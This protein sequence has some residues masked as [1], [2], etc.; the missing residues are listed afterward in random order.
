MRVKGIDKL[1]ALAALSVVI[2]HIYGSAIPGYWKYLFTGHP[3][4]IAFFVISGFC[5]HRPY[6]QNR[7]DVKAF[8]A[9]RLVRILP[10][11][12]VA[13]FFAN[14]LQMNLYNFTD[15]YIL[16]SVVCELWYYGCYP[17]FYWASKYISWKAQFVLAMLVSFTI[18][19]YFGS[20]QYGGAAVYGPYL[21]WVVALPSWLL[22]C[23]VAEQEIGKPANVYIWRLV[24]ALAAAIAYY[25]TMNTSIGFYLTMNLFA[26]LAAVWLKAEIATAKSSNWLDWIG[27]WSFSI[28]LIHMIANR[29]IEVYWAAYIPYKG[30]ALTALAMSLIFYFIVEKPSHFLARKVFKF[31]SPAVANPVQTVPAV[32]VKES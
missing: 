5:I 4:V 9:A 6:V 3:S 11:V 24:T 13:M 10:P 28:Y 17:I 8:L 26:V 12:L 21:N 22:G 19:G 15:G 27:T 1:R 30:I 14:R 2:A 20:D 31:M 25:L 7:L 16:W 23:V 29:A 18:V 32:L